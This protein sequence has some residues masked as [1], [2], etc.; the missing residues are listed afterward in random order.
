MKAYKIT[1]GLHENLGYA[2]KTFVKGEVYIPE[3][4]IRL[5]SGLQREASNYTVSPTELQLLDSHH[6]VRQIELEDAKVNAVRSDMDLIA[7][8]QEALDD[9]LS[10]L[11]I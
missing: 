11:L 1:Q 8:T 9:K 10:T 2:M 3:A 4:E 6:L 7:D 5:S